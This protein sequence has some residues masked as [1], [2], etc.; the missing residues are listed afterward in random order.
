M[1][2]FVD[3]HIYKKVKT[4]AVNGSIWPTEYANYFVVDQTEKNRPLVNHILRR[5]F[6]SF[7][8]PRAAGKSTRM[9]QLANQLESG[10][11]TVEGIKKYECFL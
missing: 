6:V 5:E 2:L 10:I 3:S 7:H 11:Q 9:L 8:A 4:F 1:I